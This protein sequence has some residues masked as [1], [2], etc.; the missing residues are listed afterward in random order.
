MRDPGCAKRSCFHEAA[1]T[2]LSAVLLDTVSMI[3]KEIQTYS[4]VHNCHAQIK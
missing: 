4:M 2:F 1:S 3:L